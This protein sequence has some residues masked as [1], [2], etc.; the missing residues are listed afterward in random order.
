MVAPFELAVRANEHVYIATKYHERER[1][2]A[3]VRVRYIR[4]ITFV[5]M[6]AICA[7]IT[8]QCSTEIGLAPISIHG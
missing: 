1:D 7:G 2:V 8:A 4:S 5:S 3:R 6:R